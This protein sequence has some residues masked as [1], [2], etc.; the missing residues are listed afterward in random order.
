MVRRWTLRA[1]RW[2]VVIAYAITVALSWDLLWP[3]AKAAWSGDR[4]PFILDFNAMMVGGEAARAGALAKAYTLEW[5]KVADAGLGLPVGK[6]LPYTYP[7]IAALVFEP[8]SYLSVPLAFL[9]FEA[10]GLA[11]FFAGVKAVSPRSAR[12]V[13]VLASV[14]IACLDLRAGQN[15]LWTAG[16]VAY[17]ARAWID[18]RSTTAGCLAALVTGKPHVAFGLPV[19]MLVARDWRGLAA[20]T[21]A[22][23]VLVTLSVAA[24]GVAPWRA[25]PA[26]MALAGSSLAAGLYPMARLSS[27]YAA[28]VGLGLHGG[29]AMAAQGVAMAGVGVACCLAARRCGDRRVTAALAIAWGSFVSP[30]AYD[31]DLTMLSVSAAL[32]APLLVE[33]AGVQVAANLLAWLVAGQFAGLTWWTVG[34][35]GGV[36]FFVVAPTVLVAVWFLMRRQYGVTVKD[37]N[38]DRPRFR[39]H[40][41]RMRSR[42]CSRASSPS[43]Q[44][45]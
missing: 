43:F 24:F 22:V 44:N 25:Y 28:A 11:L 36:V 32:I 21:A 20:M 35:R 33:R 17:A 40:R 45:V 38:D 6:W 1:E 26:A 9:V 18:G 2:I 34:G 16:V 23:A 19:S 15:G 41:R 12:V 8:L 37:G 7:P 10:A 27:A 14:P 42:G 31:Y 29:A 39:A 5:M 13:L 3:I 30:Y 4:I